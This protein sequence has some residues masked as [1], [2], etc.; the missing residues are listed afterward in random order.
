MRALFAFFVLGLTACGDDDPPRRAAATTPGWTLTLEPPTPLDQA[1]PVVAFELTGPAE[2]A[3]PS[4]PILVEGEPSK[5]SADKYAAGE[6]TEVLAERVVPSSSQ[7]DPEKL[8]LRP[9]YALALG[10]RYTLL[11]RSGVLG[12]VMVRPRIDRP[13]LARIWPPRDSVE[14]T[15]QVIYCGEVAPTESSAVSLFP[16]DISARLE[17]G[18]HGDGAGVGSCVRLLPD[19]VDGTEVQPPTNIGDVALEPAPFR[20]GVELAELVPLACDAPNYP[21]APGCLRL[22]NGTATVQGPA[23][24]TLWV[25][26][27]AFGWHSAVV[28]GGGKFVVPLGQSNEGAH[29]DAW[30]F[31]LAGR[32][33]AASVEIAPIEPVPHVIINEVMA[34]PLGTE[35]AEEWVEL[36][37][38][39][40]AS[41]TMVG[42]K[43]RDQAGEV[44]L[45]PLR[46]EPGAFVLLV[47]EDF[48]GGQAGDVAPVAGTTLVR[49]PS[50]G[51]NGLTNSGEALSLVDQGGAVV[52]RYPARASGLEGVSLARRTPDELDELA[53]GF[54]PH[55]SP[56]ASPGAANVV[57]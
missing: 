49:L 16:G 13:Y 47:R 32:S 50:L 19:M 14:A 5:I 22:D 57:E 1:E 25:L 31:D 53:Q 27:S 51:K 38:A 30:V 7:Q 17:P 3:P 34:N 46:M 28:E 37:N 23:G 41:A 36:V 6:I 42:W 10:Q 26:S 55:A 40:A 54:G 20:G 24:T 56:G 4:D 15:G 9:R 8:V 45:P 21:L 44:E 12:V 11:S 43:L 52:S 29:L 2:L 39:G 18:F 35:P 33:R 48:A